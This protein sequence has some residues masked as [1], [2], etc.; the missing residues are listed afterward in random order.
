VKHPRTRLL[1][2]TM[3]VGL[4]C[5]PACKGDATGVKASITLSLSSSSFT[6]AQGAS[7]SVTM[8]ITREGGF[9]GA[10]SIGV[11]GVPAGMDVV[12]DPTSIPD[13]STTGVITVHPGTTNLGVYR[14]AVRASAAGVTSVTA[15]FDVLV[16]ETFQGSYT[17]SVS[18][19]PLLVPQGGE[20]TATVTI[21]R[22]DFTGNVDLAVTGGPTSGL[23]ATFS[24]ASTTGNTSTL[25]IAA[26][27]SLLAATY[28]LAVTGEAEG[29]AQ[30][31]APLDVR[32]VLVAGT[33][34]TS[35]D[36]CPDRMPTWFAYQDGS[37]PWMQ[38]QPSSSTFSFQ[39][40]SGRGGVAV[41]TGGLNL[42]VYYGTQQELDANGAQC[43]GTTSPTRT[44]NGTVAGLGAVDNAFISFAGAS[45]TLTGLGGP[46][47]TLTGVFDGSFDLV[48][49]R[50]SLVIGGQSPSTELTKLIIRRGLNPADNSTLPV[51]D[52]GSAEAIDPVQ[53]NVTINN[54]GGDLSLISGFFITA[55]GGV[56]T[57]YTEIGQSSGATRQYFGVPEANRTSGDVHFLTVG[58]YSGTTFTNYRTVSNYFGQAT[59]QTVT[60]GPQ[61]TPVTVSTVATSPYARLR[62]QYTIQPEYDDLLLFGGGQA[63]GQT[64]TIFASKEYLGGSSQFDA[65]IPDFSGVNG[66]MN[67]WAPQ[68]G[69][70]ITWTFSATGYSVPGGLVTPQTDGVTAQG[71]VATGQITP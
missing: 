59:D 9:T 71:A 52:F 6:V 25:T 38:V 60:L 10:V 63:T 29:L 50:S 18:P 37:G 22:T 41:V 16:T 5:L 7:G 24:P 4:S 58:A 68:P 21:D 70:E 48:A 40:D 2:A 35:W 19:S 28:H 54:L 39:I 51:L 43:G 33:G 66:W 32:V 17:L 64:F 65:G 3:L 56:A 47:F 30:Q 67:A 11:N 49:S 15:R 1:A 12:V 31:A 14:L 55:G 27:A 20:A 8:T 42:N 69:A 61:I 62:A 53:R 44:V 34:N 57:L 36:F 26:S 46:A 45:A 13:G 23:T